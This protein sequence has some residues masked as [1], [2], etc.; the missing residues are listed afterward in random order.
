MTHNFRYV[1]N[2]LFDDQLPQSFQKLTKLKAFNILGNAFNKSI[3]G[4]I[5]EWDKLEILSLMGNNFEGHLPNKILGLPR[6]TY[7]AINNLPGGETDVLFP[8]IH[9]IVHL[10][11]LTLRSCSLTGSIPDYIWRFTNLSY[12]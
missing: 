12:L 11:S 2:N 7:L 8:D 3:P 9:N 10:K 1:M 4:Y 5:F 6:L